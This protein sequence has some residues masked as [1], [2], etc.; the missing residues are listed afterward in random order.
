MKKSGHDWHVIVARYI[1]IIFYCRRI[2]ELIN[3]KNAKDV[4]T[5]VLKY[6]VENKNKFKKYS[7]EELDEVVPEINGK[8]IKSHHEKFG[9][10]E[11]LLMT[12]ISD[13]IR[14]LY[15]AREIMLRLNI[16]S[17]DELDGFIADE[18]AKK[19]KSMSKLDDDEVKRIRYIFNNEK[20][21]DSEIDQVLSVRNGLAHKGVD[22]N[23]DED[24]LSL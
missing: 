1:D 18:A 14:L 8:S 19:H 23:L 7:N 21:L 6:A 24:A 9:S 22:I 17:P 12:M 5:F 3:S 15:I 11:D 16:A 10:I 20:P 13:N 2:L 4:D